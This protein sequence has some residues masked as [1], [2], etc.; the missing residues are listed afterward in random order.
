M[1]DQEQASVRARVL[2][3]YP[4]AQW[5][6]KAG[7]VFSPSLDA[8]YKNISGDE[9]WRDE[10]RAWES[11][12]SKLPEDAAEQMCECLHSIVDHVHSPETGKAYC[13]AC[14]CKDYCV[15]LPEDAAKAEP[16]AAQPVGVITN[17][18]IGSVS[19]VVTVVKPVAAQP[20][21]GD[22]WTYLP[23][24]PKH[25]GQVNIAWVF[26]NDKSGSG[27]FVDQARYEANYG[28]T[29][30]KG[31][32][33]H[34]GIY[35]WRDVPKAPPL[36][37]PAAQPVGEPDERKIEVCHMCGWPKSIGCHHPDS[38]IEL[39]A[40]DGL[41][42]P[43]DKDDEIRFKSGQDNFNE[44]N[45]DS[46]PYPGADTWADVMTNQGWVYAKRIA[47]IR[48]PKPAPQATPDVEEIRDKA[49]QEWWSSSSL[50]SDNGE[51]FAF[52]QGFDSGW[53]AAQ[54]YYEQKISEM[55]AN[56]ADN[57]AASDNRW[58][59]AEARGEKAEKEQ[60]FIKLA[61]EQAIRD[62]CYEG[63]SLAGTPRM[64]EYLDSIRETIE[65][66]SSMEHRPTLNWAKEDSA[67]K[68]R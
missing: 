9:W 24:L 45:T 36:P 25:G 44:G 4:D 55:Q 21:G 2:A 54:A 42:K 43:R 13:R 6:K 34:L 15:K 8:T 31:S 23:E 39:R 33:N 53:N 29:D 11:A 59:E 66:C 50:S 12:A 17:G 27:P 62:M 14:G 1:S 60:L 32:L 38:Q 65:G 47:A 30:R 67:G 57:Y 40:F 28:W 10:S 20:V 48:E 3:V 35:A 68:I 7:C 41:Y 26:K 61:A 58:H 49:N 52:N 16:V 22:E 18:K 19:D 56:A 64:Q 5:S 37:D 51:G 46:P 63:G